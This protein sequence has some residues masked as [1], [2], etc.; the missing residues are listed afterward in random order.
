VEDLTLGTVAGEVENI[1]KVSCF[2]AV[3]VSSLAIHNLRLAES[4]DA[5]LFLKFLL[6]ILLD[7]R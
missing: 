2:V 6:T 7:L 4:A 1:S 3:V 5:L